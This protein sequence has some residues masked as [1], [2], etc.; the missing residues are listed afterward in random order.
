MDNRGESMEDKGN[1]KKIMAEYL[2]LDGQKVPE[3]R[4]KTKVLEVPGDETLDKF[5]PPVWGFDGSSTMQAEG[6]QSD[7]VLKPVRHFY[8]PLRNNG[9]NNGRNTG[10]E[11]FPH[12][13]V[14]NEVMLP[15]GEPHPSNTRFRLKHLAEQHHREEFWFGI[16][17]EYTFFQGERPLGFPQKGFPEPQ[18]R[19]YCGVGAG[20]AIGREIVEKHM[21]ACLEAGLLF[22]G[23]NAEVM[24]GQWE[25][26]IG[27]GEPLAVADHLIVA[28]YL[29]E[30]IAEEQ[31]VAVSLAPKPCNG[32]WNGAGAH[33]NF[34]TREMRESGG[35]GAVIKRLAAHHDE[36]IAVYGEGIRDRLTGKHE[37]A[38]YD[39]FKSG[40]S[41]RGAS[42][43]LPWQCA[44]EGRG[45]L[46]DRRP[47]ANMDPYVVLGKI[48]ETVG[49]S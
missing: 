8:D 24:P 9:R 13:I 42:L 15:N 26:Q 38:R 41:D 16:E 27:P 20:K 23:I 19:Y 37:T 14:L 35:F 1:M 34:S 21:Q 31:G 11:I 43:R 48:M 10:K 28:R 49:K 39:E 29:M 32:D 25:Y 45:Y 36:H 44:K 2:W 46:E 40:E 33:T 7:C 18:G 4:G 17:Q 6:H 3:I 12:L 5:E 30:R 22:A 47:C